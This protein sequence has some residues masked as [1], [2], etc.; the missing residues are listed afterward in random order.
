VCCT[1]QRHELWALH[2]GWV[3]DTKPDFGAGT[4]ERF[5][6]ASQIT[7]EQVRGELVSS[8]AREWACCLCRR[9]VRGTSIVIE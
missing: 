2:G 3:R 9:R 7:Q 5:K 1:V 4:A 6:A 8:A